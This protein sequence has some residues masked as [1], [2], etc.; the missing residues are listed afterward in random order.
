MNV[1]VDVKE[2]GIWGNPDFAFSFTNPEG[3]FGSEGSFYS[4][5]NDYGYGLSFKFFKPSLELVEMPLEV[6]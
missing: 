3:I 4:V 5:N 6:P 2:F 1:N